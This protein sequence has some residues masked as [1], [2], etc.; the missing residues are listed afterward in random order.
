MGV[1]A[2]RSG[3]RPV[4]C[5]ARSIVVVGVMLLVSGCG[6]EG[7][8]REPEEWVGAAS[9]V[10]PTVQSVWGSRVVSALGRT[11]FAPVGSAFGITT[12][13]LLLTNAHVVAPEGEVVPNLQVLVQRDTSAVFY[14]AVV[15]GLDAGK[16]LAVLRIGADS[17]PIVRWT[18]EE[19]SMGTPLATIGY[20]LPE[21]GVVE[22]SDTDVVSQ[23]TVFRRF[24]AGYSSGYRTRVPGDPGTNALEAD[25]FLF[26]GVSGGPAFRR[27]GRV[28]GVDRGHR[29][30]R[31]AASSYG[32]IIPLNVVRLFLAA[33]RAETG[34]DPD[35][36]L[37]R[38][39]A[40]PSG[41]P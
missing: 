13:G 28:V 11:A 30:Y 23:F 4:A 26:P 5:R 35:S 40:V 20:G 24:T 2:S 14:D 41:R 25:L 39:G 7:G 17:L 31:D 33:V 1:M 6:P 8:A 3:H 37:G 9:A 36:V 18:D 15:V 32:V 38:R 21:G 22:A 10:R 34:I 19:A 27:D 29:E 12:D 16:D